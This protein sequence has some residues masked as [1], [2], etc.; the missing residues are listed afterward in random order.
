MVLF[1]LSRRCIRR[2]NGKEVFDMKLFVEPE[3]EITRFDIED[4][5]ATSNKDFEDVDNGI[6]W[7]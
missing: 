2:L 3:L 1:P 7:I 6:G 4:M 5:I